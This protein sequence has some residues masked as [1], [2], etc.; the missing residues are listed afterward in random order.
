MLRH[1]TGA[2]LRYFATG[3]R[4]RASAY[5]HWLLHG[6]SRGPTPSTFAR[7]VA[8]W[9]RQERVPALHLRAG[10]V[11]LPARNYLGR[12]DVS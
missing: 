4:A 10:R 6:L 11:I 2:N 9:E 8:V 3:L 12:N 1:P 7:R 5:G